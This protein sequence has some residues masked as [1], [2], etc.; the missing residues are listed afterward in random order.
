MPAHEPPAGSASFTSL[1]SQWLQ[2]LFTLTFDVGVSCALALLL[3]RAL[4]AWAAA[5]S[6]A[7]VYGACGVGAGALAL[8]R[9]LPEFGARQLLAA[10][11]RILADVPGVAHDW[12]AY[13]TAGGVQW[14][15]HSLH[16]RGRWAA[17]S[18]SGSSG[19][20]GGKSPRAAAAS[21][22]GAAAGSSSSSAAGASAGAG[23]TAAAA[24]LPP[25]PLPTVVVLHGHSCGAAHWEVML[26]ELGQHTD[27][28]VLDIPGWGRSP[29]PPQLLAAPRQAS[30][31]SRIVGLHND[32][33]EG[34]L[35]SKGLGCWGEAPAGSQQQQQ[36]LRPVVLL[37]H[38]M[39]GH[40]CANFCA[41]HPRAA[42]K[43]L[44]A[45]PVGYLPM[46]P[47]G[48]TWRSSAVF[49]CFPPQ[50]GI[51]LLGRC[52]SAFVGALMRAVYPEDNPHF[53]PYYMQ[54]AWATWH[55]G[56]CDAVYSNI[57]QARP[58]GRAMWSRPWLPLLLE[59]GEGGGGGAGAGAPPQQQLLRTPPVAVLWGTAEELMLPVWASLI[60]R[61][62][63]D[64]DLYLLRGGKHNSAHSHPHIFVAAALHALRKAAGSGGEGGA[65]RRGSGSGGGKAAGE[66]PLPQFTDMSCLEGMAEAAALGTADA[67]VRLAVGGGGRQRQPRRCR[68][69]S[70]QQQ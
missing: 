44:L 51:R 35:R 2:W 3:A 42:A 14:R 38:S 1:R 11:A 4:G 40:I 13:A 34:W 63:P 64:T 49:Y 50:R 5:P 23:A 56:A 41:A 48:R 39:G 17:G 47:G 67:I 26:R 25:P 9:L 70:S 55:T 8:L 16:V 65:R 66:E 21:A 46:Q 22:A 33:L 10:E 60:H 45:S 12:A 54:L 37:G 32:M 27:V 43:L 24:A 18:G 36:P 52:F 15:V 7:A 20:N 29:A 31:A 19:S 30:C 61:L 68:R 28:W 6:P 69:G 59:R 58:G 57:F 53:I 62:R